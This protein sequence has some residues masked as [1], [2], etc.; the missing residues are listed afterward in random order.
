MKLTFVAIPLSLVMAGTGWWL[1][2]RPRGAV[3]LEEVP[4]DIS[5]RHPVTDDMQRAAASLSKSPLAPINEL[6]LKG[7]KVTTAQFKQ[8]QPTVMVFIKNSCPCSIDAQPF[9]NELSRMYGN[10]V[11]FWGVINGEKKDA[12]AYVRYN[13]VP[14]PAMVDTDQSVIKAFGIKASASL[15]LVDGNGEIRQVWP[16]YSQAVLRQVNF[17]LAG[18]TASAPVNLDDRNAPEK[19]TAGCPFE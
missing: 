19:L 17:L 14:F 5:T 3:V 15:A 10:K 7:A 11:Q 16:G 8:G 2:T 12:E 4:L 13:R 9:F 18:L 6:D 1:S